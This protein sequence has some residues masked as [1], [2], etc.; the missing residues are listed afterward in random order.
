MQDQDLR[1]INLK[2]GDAE[3]H[4]DRDWL[5]TILAP[6]LVFQRANGTI[7][8]AESYLASV[9]AGGDRETRNLEVQVLGKRA[10]VRCLVR[11]GGKDYDNLRLF[12]RREGSWFLMA[13]VNE[14]ATVTP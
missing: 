7:E 5:A 11:S 10:I 6:A 4:G 3:N 1:E 2:I 8:N 13:W 12:V 14:P 9:K